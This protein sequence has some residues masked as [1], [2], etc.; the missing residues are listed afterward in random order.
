MCA[1]VGNVNTGACDAVREICDAAHQQHAW[2]HVDGAFR[3]W[4]ATAPA[5]CHLTEGVGA[6]DSWATDAHKWLNV[7]QDCGIAIVRDKRHL[8]EAMAITASY[9]GSSDRREP[10]QYG[11]ESSRRARAVEIWAALRNL[12]RQGVADLVERTCQ[13]A[14]RFADRLQS[15]GFEILNEVVLN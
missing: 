13:H 1:Q 4:A 14:R 5:R 3:L 11:P 12:G 7:P 15:A 10:M 6:A 9:L 8:R 2:V